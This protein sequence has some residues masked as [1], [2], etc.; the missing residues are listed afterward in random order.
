M[1]IIIPSWLHALNEMLQQKVEV[2]R[3]TRISGLHSSSEQ[4]RACFKTSKD[5]IL[6]TGYFMFL[7]TVG[8]SV[9]F[10]KQLIDCT[11]FQDR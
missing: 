11:F 10:D 2:V 3:S 6:S 8:T 4:K 5:A 7:C 9:R 1:I